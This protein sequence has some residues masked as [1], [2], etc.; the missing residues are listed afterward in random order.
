[1]F[2]LSLPLERMGGKPDRGDENRTPS[3][4]AVYR[5][6]GQGLLVDITG[7]VLCENSDPKSIDS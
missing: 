7:P 3:V 5:A 6:S 4:T 1:M 2:F